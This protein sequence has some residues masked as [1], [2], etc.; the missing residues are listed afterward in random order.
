MEKLTDVQVATVALSRV[1]NQSSEIM[2]LIL[3]GCNV[4]LGVGGDYYDVVLTAYSEK[5]W[6]SARKRLR[7]LAESVDRVMGQFCITLCIVNEPI[8]TDDGYPL[9]EGYSWSEVERFEIGGQKYVELT[10]DEKPKW[11]RVLAVDLLELR[12]SPAQN[13]K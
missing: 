3:Q 13:N 4:A 2:Q 9:D 12:F 11:V 8:G 6:M 5:I 7:E 10:V 1:Y